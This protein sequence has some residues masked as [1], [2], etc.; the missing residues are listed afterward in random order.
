MFTARDTPQ[1]IPCDNWTTNQ[2]YCSS[3]RWIV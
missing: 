1:S 3:F 2:Y